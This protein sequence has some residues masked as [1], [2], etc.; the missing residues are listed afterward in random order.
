MKNRLTADSEHSMTSH[1][2]Q[3]ELNNV[4]KE[5]DELRGVIPVAT[6]GATPSA[7]GSDLK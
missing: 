4:A 2:L 7:K 5:F 6:S 3:N 1:D